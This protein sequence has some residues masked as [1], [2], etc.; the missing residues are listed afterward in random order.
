MT[1]SILLLIVLSALSA[2]GQIKDRRA[3]LEIFG[4]IEEI[5]V[6]PDEHI[7]LVT[8]RGETFYTTNIDSSW[9]SGLP[10]SELIEKYYLTPHFERI[11]FFNKDTGI[12]TGYISTDSNRISS[13]GYYLT[14]D[15]GNSWELLDYG[16]SSW[17]YTAVVDNKGNAWLGGSGKRIHYSN[18]YGRNWVP[19]TIPYKTS[20]RTYSLYMVDSENGVAGS[21]NNEVIVTKDNWKTVTYIATPY[22]QKKL[23][24]KIRDKRIKKLLLWGDYIV[25]S[26]DN[27]VFYTEQQ[28]IDW[29]PFPVHIVDF[30]FDK[31]LS[32]LFV[33]TDSL[34]I[35]LFNSPN[36]WQIID[37]DPL[38][39]YPTDLVVVNQNLYI[40]DRANRVYAVRDREVTKV[41]PYTFDMTWFE[42][43][44][45][46]KSSPND[47]GAVK[48]YIY[49]STTD[50]IDWYRFDELPFFIADMQLIDSN[51]AILW[52][53]SNRAYS[54]SLDDRTLKPYTFKRPLKEFLAS[55]IVSFAIQWGQMDCFAA[56]SINHEYKKKGSESILTLDLSKSR[57]QFAIAE[58]S[59]DSL[60]QILTEIDFSPSRIPD[61]HQFNI[62]DQDKRDFI[63]HIYAIQYRENVIREALIEYEGADDGTYRT[64]DEDFYSSVVY[65]V[66]TLESSVLANVLSQPEPIFSTTNYWIRVVIVN[67]NND[68]VTLSRKYEEVVNPWFMPWQ[69]ECGKLHFNCYNLDFSKFIKWKLPRYLPDYVFTNWYLLKKIGDYL[70]KTQKSNYR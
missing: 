6:S 17:I 35:A 18:D 67:D 56:F 70:Y 11:S 7:W 10:S 34:S 25:A 4:K 60:F 55:S 69:A 2:H 50:S 39:S 46:R 57:S 12:L 13:N 43:A 40:L 15:G 19:L 54:Y 66:D 33:V 20:D 38:D 36:D 1:R 32:R 63:E 27:G 65:I 22:D 64:I 47:W 61:I 21:D 49:L 42:P 37:S 44:I 16:G 52:D 59:I 68:T 58:I 9:H 30:A 62:T 3:D 23:K 41:I 48:Q 14:I 51:N 45:V 5:S 28:N 31:K 26:Q 8:S 29:K 24:S 53:N